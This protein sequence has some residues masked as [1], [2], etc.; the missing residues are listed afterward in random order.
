MAT[1][2]MR[3]VVT[4]RMLREGLLRCLER[5]SIDKISVSEL[6]RESGINRATFYNHYDAPRDILVD[7]GWEAAKD[8]KALFA[9]SSMSSQREILVQCLALLQ[10]NKREVK[11]IIAASADE[12]L[13]AAAL[14]IFK[15]LL[16]DG[17]DLRERYN[18]KDEVEYDLTVR[19]FG[20]LAYNLISRWITEDVD[21]TPEEIADLFIRLTDM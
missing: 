8:L 6:C 19:C 20:G 1:D 4:K 21:K 13:V 18:L 5:V 12:S 11:A 15:W 10:K 14:G 9:G 3:V 17:N 7:L 16:G 2:N